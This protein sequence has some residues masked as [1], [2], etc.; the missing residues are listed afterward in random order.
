MRI[1]RVLHV[2]DGIG[3]Y[4]DRDWCDCGNCADCIIN[5]AAQRLMRAYYAYGDVYDRQP[6]PSRDGINGYYWGE[7]MLFGFTSMLALRQWFGR[8]LPALLRDGF[9]IAE[10]EAHVDFGHQG[11]SGQAIFDITSAEFVDFH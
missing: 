11:F 7:S 4:K 2:N 8:L 3:P 1:F 10:Y 9:I 6:V 5:N